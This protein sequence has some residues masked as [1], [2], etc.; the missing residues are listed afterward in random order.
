LAGIQNVSLVAL[1]CGNSSSIIISSYRPVVMA[2]QAK[3]YFSI[4]PDPAAENVVQLKTG[5]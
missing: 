5:S 1:E 3:S 2:A 4:M